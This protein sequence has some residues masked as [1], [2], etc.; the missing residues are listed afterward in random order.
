MDLQGTVLRL[1]G[2]KHCTI[3]S[4]GT[5]YHVHLKKR[6]VG[7]HPDEIKP[8][9]VGDLVV[10]E[11]L[12]DGDGW[13]KEVLPRKSWLMRAAVGKPGKQ[14]VVVANVEQLMVI[15]SVAQPPFNPGIIDRFLV[16]A[17]K[18]KLEPIIVV[19]K[20]DL[21]ANEPSW[22]FVEKEFLRVYKRLK[23]RVIY[24]SIYEPESLKEL[25]AALSNHST[26]VAGHSGV[27]K[28]SLLSAVD[29]NIQL[30]VNEINPKSQKGR[31]T[32][33][34]VTLFPLQGGGI[35]VDT[36]GI[37]NMSIWQMKPWELPYYF[38]EMASRLDT[39]KYKKCSHTHEPHCA[40]KIA[41][42]E[43]KIAVFRYQSYCRILDSILHPETELIDSEEGD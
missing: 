25:K 20:C 14:Q 39:C 16:A 12:V 15:S 10:F 2:T 22:P 11:P 34:S 29:S 42:E 23:Y 36:P 27:G 37:R 8:V 5:T 40:I 30:R 26:V 21:Q 13:V 4:E 3:L 18:G 33:T 7:S 43:K 9:A 35:V 17:A 24:T 38:P 41:L 6:I 28:S 1:D 31:H 32:T 19:N